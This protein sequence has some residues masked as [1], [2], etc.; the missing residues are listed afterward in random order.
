MRLHARS[1][2]LGL[3]LGSE[4]QGRDGLGV[5]ELLPSCALFGASANGVRVALARGV[6]AGLLVSP[7][8]GH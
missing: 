5:S 1:L 6:S 3:L 2:I 8:R 7:R 4:S